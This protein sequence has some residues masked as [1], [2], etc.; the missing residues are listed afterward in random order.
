LAPAGIEK[1]SRRFLLTLGDSLPLFAFCCRNA[2]APSNDAMNWLAHLFLSEPSSEFRIGNLLP[3]ILSAPEIQ[4]IPRE[5]HRGIACHRAIDR[6]T[7]LHP[8]FRRSTRRIAPPFRKYGGILVDIFY[9]HFLAAS[10]SD[11]AKIPLRQLAAETYA[12][13]ETHRDDLPR[14]AYTRLIQIKSGDWLCSYGNLDGVR[15]ALAGI[16]LRLRRP[17]ELGGA[18]EQLRLHYGDLRLDFEEFFPEL[19]SHVMQRRD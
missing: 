17:R 19:L 3:D 5:F 16:G 18:V 15:R 8:V 6:F 11:H 1:S 10:W 14:R 2:D 13:I 4:A 9:D 12:A 7:D